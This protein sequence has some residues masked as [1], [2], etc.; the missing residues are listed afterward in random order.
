MFQKGRIN[1]CF[2]ELIYLENV[3]R[4]ICDS[5]AIWYFYEICVSDENHL[6]D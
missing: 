4:Q 2:S 1:I 6:T 3:L 5:G